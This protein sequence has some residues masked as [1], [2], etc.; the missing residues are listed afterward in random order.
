MK[1]LVATRNDKKLIELRRVLESAEIEGIELLSLNDVE[2]FPERPEDGRNFED[3]ALIKALDG[4]LATGLPCFAD[5]SGLS[6]DEM[7][8]MPGVLS[9]RWSGGHGDDSANNNLLLKQLRDIPAGRRGAAF[10]S[11]VV[12][13]NPGGES[14]GDGI[15]TDDGHGDSIYTFRGEWRGRVSDELRGEHGFGYDPLFIPH[16]EDQRVKAGRDTDKFPEPRSAAQLDPEDKDE[17]SHRGRSL[18]QLIPTIQRL[19]ETDGS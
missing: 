13:V 8:G 15:A 7:N 9:A 6:V 2:E 12:L 16:E 14:A 5:D 18:R 10:V 11:A 1:L 19:V 4:A 17:L 3:N